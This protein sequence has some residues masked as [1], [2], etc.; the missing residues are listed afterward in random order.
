MEASHTSMPRR[1]KSVCRPLSTSSALVCRASDRSV[2]LRSAAVVRSVTSSDSAAARFESATVQA[3]PALAARVAGLEVERAVPSGEVDELVRPAPDLLGS[4]VCHAA[5]SPRSYLSCSHRPR[6]SA[7]PAPPRLGG[8]RSQSPHACSVR[9]GTASRPSRPVPR[10]W[11]DATDRAS[12]WRY[13]RTHGS[14]TL[15]TP[16]LARWS[17]SLDHAKLAADRVLGLSVGGR[18]L[19]V[20]WE[21]TSL[22]RRLHNGHVLPSPGAKL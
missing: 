19:Q 4:T 5:P 20:T 22:V 10:L 2:V 12:H 11:P 9:S 3:A 6:R 18:R 15:A 14:A 1:M 17:R 8:G 16:A 7:R 13:R 21:A